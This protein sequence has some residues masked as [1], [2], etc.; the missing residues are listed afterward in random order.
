MSLFLVFNYLNNKKQNLFL[1]WMKMTY[2]IPARTDE[3]YNVVGLSLEENK[4]FWLKE[5]EFNYQ[6]NRLYKVLMITTSLILNSQHFFLIYEG[7]DVYA[8]V[9][10]TIIHIIHDSYFIFLI[11]HMIY[12]LNVFFI[13]ILLFY[14]QKIQSHF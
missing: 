11:F 12:T 9:I 3:D 8:Y 14:S 7:V 10:L 13:T 5:D 6:Y 4:K 2:E 1:K